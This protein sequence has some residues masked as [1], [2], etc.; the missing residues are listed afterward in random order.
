MITSPKQFNRL[1]ALA[2]NAATLPVNRIWLAFFRPDMAYEKGSHTLAGT[3]FEVGTGPDKGFAALKK[4][5]EKLQKGGVEVF[6]SVGGWDWNCFP[7]AYAQYSIAG[8]GANAPNF[9]HIQKYAGGDVS[10]CTKENQYCYVCEPESAGEN[11]NDYRMFPEPSNST[12]WKTAQ[13][14]VGSSAIWHPQIKPGIDYTDTATGRTEPVPG[15]A[16]YEHSTSMDPYANFV[17]LAAD[18]GVAGIDLDYEEFWHADAFKTVAPGGTPK[19]GPYLIH[20]TVYKFAAIA[21]DLIINIKQRAPHLKLSTPAGAVSAWTSKWWGGNLKGLLTE[22]KASYPS[23]IDFMTTGKNAGGINVM[24]YDLSDDQSHN[25][26]PTTNACTLPQQVDFYMNTYATAGIPAAVGYEVGT[27]AYPS[28]EGEGTEHQLPLTK[29]ALS[30]IISQ[31]QTKHKAVGGFFWEM[32]KPAAG[33]AS[34][35]D[36]AQAICKE[37]LGS[38]NKRCSGV[39]PA[40]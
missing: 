23:V 7:Y 10:K 4:A 37:V 2:K 13:D 6:L 25:E 14:F 1:T 33:H 24:T 40:V 18:L 34:P 19:D 21:Q 5:I 27:P 29:D 32:F 17:Q 20:Q 39:I 36:V 31:T 12:T 15:S 16:D 26:C 3:G 22:V 28:A 11:F 8:Y 9:W 35:T 30:Q 38:A